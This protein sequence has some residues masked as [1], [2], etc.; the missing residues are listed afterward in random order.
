MGVMRYAY[1]LLG[2]VLFVLPVSASA[3]T[4]F[5]VTGWIPY[6]RTATGT[7]DVLPHLSEL[8]EVNPFVYTLKSDGTLYDN[9]GLDT[10]PWLSFV[11]AAKAQ[12]VRVIPTVM[13]PGGAALHAILSNT[14][15]RVALETNI[16]NLVKQK[17]YDGIDIDFEGKEAADKNYFSTFLKGLYQRM[18]TKWVMCDIEARTPLDS[19]YYG[20]TIPPD[21]SI[22]ANDFVQ[23]N[24]YC[25]R[26]RLMTYDQ[27]GVDQQLATAAASS[28]QIYAPIAD[29]AWVTKVVKL[30]EQSINKNKILIGVPTYGYEYDVTTYAGG[31]FTYDTLW[32]F[33]PAYAST[34]AA[35]YGIVPSRNSSG[36]MQ[37]TY[38]PAAS[39][40]APVSSSLIPALGTANAAT[41]YADSLN[42]H[43]SFRLVD[44]PD[45][46]SIA[47][48]AALAKSLGVRGI[49]IFKLD[50][51]EDPNMWAALLGVKR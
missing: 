29:P 42:S 27:Q 28:S 18:G 34:T 30:A 43:Q 20:T 25:D 22:Y 24:K 49:S 36:E 2:L 6:W 17:G 47:S 39:T 14:T 4:S 48:K 38:F 35:Q 1:G 23:I 19:R 7:A 50:G 9:G 5:E 46:Q 3:A 13:S 37:F 45:A 41:A 44:W 33:N 12:K 10:E 40:T 31:Q 32:T 26:V 11:S 8:T 51:E 21:A 16:A 15:K